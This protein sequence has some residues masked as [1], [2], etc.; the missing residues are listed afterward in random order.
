MN[1]LLDLLP[2]PAERD[3]PAGQLEARR[4]ALVAA[5]RADGT[6]DPLARRALHAARGGI[7]RT[8]LTL[9]GILA[10]GIALLMLGFSA[11]QRSVRTDA[12]A[13]LAA[14]GTVQIAAAVAPRA[15][16]AARH[17]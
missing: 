11:P 13:V 5:V 4:D 6:S 17:L 14:A 12:V 7:A 9:L 2:I 8:W 16:S 3:F 1:E 15:G 10:V